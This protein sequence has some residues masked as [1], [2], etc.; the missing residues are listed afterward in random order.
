MD[1]FDV[2]IQDYLEER[3]DTS[4]SHERQRGKF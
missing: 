1:H 3:Y 2:D 4:N